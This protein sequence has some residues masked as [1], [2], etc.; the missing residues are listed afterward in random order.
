[1]ADV[2]LALISPTHSALQ[3]MTNNLHEHGN[4]VGLR[5]SHERTKAMVI[6]QDQHH[7][8]L[9]LGELDIEYVQNFTYLGSNIS[10][11]GAQSCRSIPTA[12]Q[13]LV[14]QRHHY[15]HQATPLHGISHTNSDL[16]L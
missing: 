9:S 5:I 12:P 16:R 2:A 13:H 10:G 14:V 4:K 1:M 11:K 15:S 3:S 6:R 8:P 7:P